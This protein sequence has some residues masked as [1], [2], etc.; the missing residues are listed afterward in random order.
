M[1]RFSVKDKLILSDKSIGLECKTWTLLNSVVWHNP[2]LM[3]QALGGE[4]IWMDLDTLLSHPPGNPFFFN[5]EW[6]ISNAR[7]KYTRLK[8]YFSLIAFHV[9]SLIESEYFEVVNYPTMGLGLM[10]IKNSTVDELAEQIP[11]YL[12][13]IS[14]ALF[15]TLQ[16]LGHNSLYQYRD[17]N[18]ITHRCILYG[19]LSLVNSKANITIGFLQCDPE[20][21][22]EIY[23]E[24]E[25]ITLKTTQQDG[26]YTFKYETSARPF[27]HIERT[28]YHTPR[29]YENRNPNPPFLQTRYT[30]RELVQRVKISW[31]GRLSDHS[32]RRSIRAGS[33]IFINYKW[34]HIPEPEYIDL[35][36][37]EEEDDEE[38]DE[39]DN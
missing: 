18:N 22:T 23:F 16:I 27:D 31:N 10:A 13:Y 19:P 25:Y 5:E 28:V 29:H 12:E 30:K 6:F 20:N 4:N 8:E 15:E 21:H 35:T 24:F 37:S 34:I 33:Q 38:D 14:E 39:E 36:L 7:G 9:D 32:E 11:G 2:V 17:I 1:H 3:E 26:G